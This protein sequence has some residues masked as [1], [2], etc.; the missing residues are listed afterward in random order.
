MKREQIKLHSMYMGDVVKTSPI[1]PF[2]DSDDND[3]LKSIYTMSDDGIFH[4]DVA[5]FLSNEVRPELREFIKANLLQKHESIGSIP[6][7]LSEQ[8]VQTLS[9]RPDDTFDS[10]S[11]RVRD[12]FSSIVESRKQKENNG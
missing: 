7:G 10:Y 4:G 1:L 6:D 3:I 11:S 8:D 2:V 12:Y 9:L 5:M